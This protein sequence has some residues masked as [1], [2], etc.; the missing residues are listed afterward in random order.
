MD[1][2][3]K[4]HTHAL[5]VKHM[6]KILN[7]IYNIPTRET[8]KLNRLHLC[9]ILNRIGYNARNH[10]GVVLRNSNN[11]CYIDATLLALFHPVI[12]WRCKNLWYDYVFKK[13]TE[14]VSTRSELNTI[15]FNIKSAF[16]DVCVES[17]T[18]TAL[19]TLFKNHPF[20]FPDNEWLRTQMDPSDVIGMI[21][22]V[23]DVPSRNVLMNGN[24]TVKTGLIA[25]SIMPYMLEQY[26]TLDEYVD[27]QN[28]RL[29]RSNFMYVQ[30]YRNA[31][32][33]KVRSPFTCPPK[34]HGLDLI[35][36]II[37]L[38]VSNNHGHY[39]A[40]LR[41]DDATWMYCDDMDAR[42]VPFCHSD[43]YSF[44]DG[45]LVT[46]GVGFLYASIK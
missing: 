12:T 42:M 18:C 38:G 29:I 41:V 45:I 32:T 33:H 1:M 16:R 39:V 31:G 35:S 20:D 36:A 3:T 26:K 30:I 44:R 2:D 28:P 46:C 15:L 24:E 25:Y 4:A 40:M 14:Y 22:R 34:I 7:K 19:R 8:N 5:S 21:E 11:S 9:V 43:L 27:D 17:M 37:H 6:R 23:F 10:I 13:G